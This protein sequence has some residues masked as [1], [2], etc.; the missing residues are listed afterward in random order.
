MIYLVTLPFWPVFYPSLGMSVIST[1]LN[2][3]NIPCKNLYFN[4]DFAV[5]FGIYNYENIA[6]CKKID[7]K[8]LDWLYTDILW[9]GDTV[10]TNDDEYFKYLE[11]DD[12]ESLVSQ[13]KLIKNTMIEPFLERSIRK[14][15]ITD[16]VK[17]VG[18][19]C[20]FQI[21]PYLAFGK[22]LK[23][24]YPH[25]KLV[26]GG[27]SLHGDIGEEIF[28]KLE[29]IDAMCI[30]EAE[31]ITV[32]LFK[33]L[34]DGT[35]PLGLSG[36][37]YRDMQDNEIIKSS[38]TIVSNEVFDNDLIPE[39]DDYFESLQSLEIDKLVPEYKDYM[40][41]PFEASRGCWWMEKQGC[42]FCGL[43]GIGSNKYRLKNPDHVLKMLEH[44]S[45]KYNFF[46]FQSCENNMDMS[47]FDS[48][49]P[50]L[51]EQYK[52]DKPFFYY[53]VK[54]NLNREQIK[55]LA[56][57]GIAVVQPGIES[58]SDHLLKLMNKGVSAIQNI[59][60]LKCAREYGLF[61]YW[62]ILIRMY[63]EAQADYNAM[64]D[65]I[66]KIVHL[67]PP[68]I[69]RAFII[70]QRY[71]TY[72]NNSEIYFN[73]IKPAAFYD[74]VYPHHFDFNRLSYFY[75]VEWRGLEGMVYQPL[76]DKVTNWHDLWATADSV[77]QLTFQIDN[78]GFV[79]IIDTRKGKKIRFDLDEI[80]SGIYLL[81]DDVISEEKLR[82]HAQNICENGKF[83]EVIKLFIDKDL[84]ININN[85]YL[86]LALK[87]DVS[88][89]KQDRM[90]LL[91]S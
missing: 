4:H 90:N 28:D 64:V 19:S 69:S 46:R 22:R 48:F 12:D 37:L 55:Q 83:E 50:K 82:N 27:A 73:K 67:N 78:E 77:P 60:F 16:D 18:F 30:G 6:S 20:L 15:N 34:S 10:N 54:S 7:P 5:E 66:P 31:E 74:F 40:A 88:W 86:G 36:V 26:Y 2:N 87:K 53:C 59:F 17:V 29:W 23:E 47:Y 3:A 52:D 32:E 13:L 44:Y 14:M 39:F 68:G 33:N 35:T 70:C 45:N 9:A 65:I 61:S 75:D 58:L 49:L 1:L 76:I 80:E 56:D 81:L 43:N 25:I 89:S 24:L 11:I 21:T 85:E 72:F 91:Q 57:S 42:A 79:Q 71:S 51:K 84:V 62:Y 41:L 63:G 8:V 38:G